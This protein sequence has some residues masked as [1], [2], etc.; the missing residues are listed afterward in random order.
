MKSSDRDAPQ[1]LKCDAGVVPARSSRLAIEGRIYT[2]ATK[3]SSEAKS[4]SLSAT[5]TYAYGGDRPYSN[6]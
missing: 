4:A 2:A 1:Y 6:R 5:H 3:N